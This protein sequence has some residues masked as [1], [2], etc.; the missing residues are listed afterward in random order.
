M[1]T[2]DP[3]APASDYDELYAWIDEIP[4]SRPKKNIQRDFSDGVAAA[5]VIAHFLPKFVDLHNY[6]PA[7]GSAQKIY[8]WN[9]LNQKVLRKLNCHLSDTAI[10]AIVNKQPGRIEEFLGELRTKI[11]GHIIERRRSREHS[12]HSRLS[13]YALAHPSEHAFDD[14][15]GFNY[16]QQY[17]YMN[18]ALVPPSHRGSMQYPVPPGVGAAYPFIAAAHGESGVAGGGGAGGTRELTAELQETVGILQVKARKLEELLALKDA[19]IDELELRLKSHG[20][21]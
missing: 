13:M 14:P 7:N 17:P 18:P 4:L 3:A 11:N 2:S 21:L 15:S 16:Q 5:E 10:E 12:V 20:L 19:R 6:P 8:N 9:T 1:S